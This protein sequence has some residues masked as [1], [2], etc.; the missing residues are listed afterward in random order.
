MLHEGNTFRINGSFGA[1]E[2]ILIIV[3]IKQTRNFASIY[4]M[5]LIIIVCLLMEQKYL[6][7]K[8]I[9]KILFFQ[10][11]FFWEVALMDLVLLSL[12]NYL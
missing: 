8:P 5:L 6:V 11:S 9:L 2:K 4:T 12:K 3:L 1:A 7:F 10:H